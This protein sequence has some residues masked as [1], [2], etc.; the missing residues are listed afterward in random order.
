MAEMVVDDDPADLFIPHTDRLT[1]DT[2]TRRSCIMYLPR[3]SLYYR[4]WFAISMYKGIWNRTSTSNL[5]K[6]IK[7]ELP[8]ISSVDT[9][10]IMSVQY[11][12]MM[13]IR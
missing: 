8:K 1:R 12:T 2:T 11:C 5:W 3:D 9:P 13:E 4:T 6:R 7:N 10:T